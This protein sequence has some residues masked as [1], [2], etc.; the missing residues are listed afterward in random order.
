M[1][2][3]SP[4]HKP[5]EFSSRR[6]LS[7]NNM[8]GRFKKHKEEKA[9]AKPAAVPARR[10]SH[11]EKKERNETPEEREKRK[12]ER[13]QRHQQRRE[14]KMKDAYQIRNFDDL[15]EKFMDLVV[16][17]TIPIDTVKQKDNFLIILNCLFFMK[18]KSMAYY[19][20]GFNEQPE[21]VFLKK[22]KKELKLHHIPVSWEDVMSKASF[23]K[24][25]KDIA[26]LM[27]AKT[28]RVYTGKRLK[29]K[30]EEV[31][32]CFRDKPHHR[33]DKY[34][35]LSNIHNLQLCDCPNIAKFESGWVQSE[36]VWM[37]LHIGGTSGKVIAETMRVKKAIPF[38]EKIA[39]YVTKQLL[40]AV[41]YL[42]A[43]DFV[44]R[45]LSLE[46]VLLCMN[47]KLAYLG[48]SFS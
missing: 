4:F 33:R 8:L 28:L 15:P 14:E 23:S 22:D 16:D 40:L 27:Q 6:P 36:G 24:A 1:P 41:Q 47:G 46:T 30:K 34:A 10:G 25:Y 9:E 5:V 19:P 37:V 39:A 11:K 20:N 3:L 12:Q 42:H 7:K 35:I 31:L 38:G 2:L 44:V 26:C 17:S 29:G 45:S 48:N 18:K 32:L 13:K 21:A 43:K